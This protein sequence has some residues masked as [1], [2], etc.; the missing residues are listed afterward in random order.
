MAVDDMVVAKVEVVVKVVA[1]VVAA[2]VMVMEEVMV[3]KLWLPFLTLSDQPLCTKAHLLPIP[4]I[5][6][7]ALTAASLVQH[8]PQHMVAAQ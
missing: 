5:P 6:T 8:Q 3:T 2:E 7:R 1:V 4:K